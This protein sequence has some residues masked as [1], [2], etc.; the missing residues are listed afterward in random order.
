MALTSTITSATSGLK[1][2]S[3]TARSAA[4]NIANINTPGYEASD[5]AQN[6]VYSGRNPG[7]GSSVNAQ[8]IGSGLTPDLGEEIGRLIEAKTVYRANIEVLRTAD[9]LSRETFDT[10][11]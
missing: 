3:L 5:V 2:A 6:T 11:A 8:L 9:E 1:A 7:G 10:L 4:D